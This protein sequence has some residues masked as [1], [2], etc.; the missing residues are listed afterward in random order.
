MDHLLSAQDRRDGT[1]EFAFSLTKLEL[2]STLDSTMSLPVCQ[3]IWFADRQTQIGF[4]W[5]VEG[6]ML[7]KTESSNWRGAEEGNS[8]VCL[9]EERIQE[10]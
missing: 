2:L 10:P 9:G 1:P 7:K 6:A 8:A 3:T 5:Q 4:F